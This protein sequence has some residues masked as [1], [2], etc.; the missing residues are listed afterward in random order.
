MKNKQATYQ[1]GP[2]SLADLFPLADSP[3]LAA[4]IK[5]LEKKVAS[6]ESHRATLD[7]AMPQKAFLQII[8]GLEEITRLMHRIS[9]YAELR[10]AEDTQDQEATTL[11]A[12]MEQMNAELSNRT[13]FF[14]LWWKSLDDDHAGHLM[15]NTGDYRYW[16]EEMRHF[17]PYTLS[18]PEEKIVNIKDVTGSNALVVLYDTITNRYAFKVAVDL[19]LIHI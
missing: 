9:G 2:W 14:S 1:Q 6:F 18:E 11:L 16:L 5:E 12:R 10:F 4:A 15:Q 7:A 8:R 13:M 3:E 19:S 17:K